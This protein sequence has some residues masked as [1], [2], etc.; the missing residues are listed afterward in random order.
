[1]E[2]CQQELQKKKKAVHT[3]DTSDRPSP[4][5]KINSWFIDIA[6]FS[7]FSHNFPKSSLISLHLEIDDIHPNLCSVRPSSSFRTTD[8]SKAVEGDASDCS[9]SGCSFKRRMT[10]FQSFLLPKV[11]I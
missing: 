7:V 3:F 5:D 8:V 9:F 4:C 11:D 2:A 10:P 1:M 6:A